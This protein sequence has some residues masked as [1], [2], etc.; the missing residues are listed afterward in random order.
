MELNYQDTLPKRELDFYDTLTIGDVLNLHHVSKYL[1]F[2]SQHPFATY[3]NLKQ[4]QLTISTKLYLMKRWAAD[5]TPAIWSKVV[6][7]LPAHWIIP[8][9]LVRPAWF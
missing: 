7:E 8:H 9:E 1:D 2:Q 5:L 3:G 6:E 4:A